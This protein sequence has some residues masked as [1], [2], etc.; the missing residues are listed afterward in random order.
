MVRGWVKRLNSAQPSAMAAMPQTSAVHSSACQAVAL[1]VT[2]QDQFH[3][4]SATS[5]EHGHRR[6]P[7]LWFEDGS[8]VLCAEGTLFR[9]HMS[10]LSRHSVCFRDM[11]AIPQPSRNPGITTQCVQTKLGPADARDDHL[12]EYDGCP[13]VHLHDIA[14]DV[15]NLLTAL[16]DGPYARLC[17]FLI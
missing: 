15:G 3:H 9:V 4:S 10:L 11:F 2:D 6:H 1:T 13:V 5:A 14:E 12:R 17:S 7:D 8:V 16:Y